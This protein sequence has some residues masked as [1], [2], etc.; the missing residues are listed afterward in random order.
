MA[1][2]GGVTVQRRTATARYRKRNIR[3]SEKEQ[4]ALETL[5]RAE[6]LLGSLQ[7]GYDSWL[8]VQQAIEAFE[9]EV[10]GDQP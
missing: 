3:M 10:M 9:T 8:L 4:E 2:A 6:R 1:N 7:R 5:R